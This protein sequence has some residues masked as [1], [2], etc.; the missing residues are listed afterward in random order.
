MGQVRQEPS[1]AGAGGDGGARATLLRAGDSHGPWEPKAAKGLAPHGRWKPQ[2]TPRP[3][4][5]PRTERSGGAAGGCPA[6]AK[7]VPENIPGSPNPTRSAHRTQ[8][9]NGMRERTPRQAG[10][11]PL[12]RAVTRQGGKAASLTSHTADGDTEVT[13]AFPPATESAQ[14]ALCG[15]IP[16]QRRRDASQT[17]RSSPAAGER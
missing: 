6:A 10:H 9:A 3:P 12:V 11:N 17:Y 14:S 7:S 1:P 4:G 13:A 16:Q 5:S 2:P 8:E 15:N